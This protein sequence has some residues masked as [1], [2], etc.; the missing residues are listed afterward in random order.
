MRIIILTGLTALGIGAALPAQAAV[1]VNG[2]GSVTFNNA[3]GTNSAVINYNGLGGDPKIVVPGL[4]GQLTLTLNS[5]VG[6][7]FNFGYSMLNNSTIAGTRISGMGFNVD[8][9]VTGVSSTGIF[10]LAEVGGFTASF[11][12]ETCFHGGPG[13]CPQSNPGNS[14]GFGETGAGTLA[15]NFASPLTS[16]TLS[17]FLDRY[18]GFDTTVS[19]QNITSAVGQ[20]TP[21][22]GGG[23]PPPGA[24]PEPATWATMILGFGLIGGA[25]RRRQRQMVRFHFA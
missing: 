24:V 21:V 5:I 15:F 13:S 7:T 9:N 20:G 12:S 11:V 1:I 6:N 14:I 2:D 17:N 18:Q 19:G 4:S 8:P 10:N 22:R 16:I 3:A 23:V 25:M